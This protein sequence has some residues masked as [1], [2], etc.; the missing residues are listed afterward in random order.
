MESNVLK[1]EFHPVAELFPL[2]QGDEFHELAQDIKVNG[3][4]EPIWLHPDGRVL[5]GRN[6]YNACKEV[7]VEP[8]YRTWDGQG[9]LVKFVVSLNLHRRHL[10]S[11][12]RAMVAL[13]AEEELGKEAKE[14]QGQ[15][16]DLRP[17]NI[18]EQ[19]PE[20]EPGEREAR[21]QAADLLGTNPHYV[22]DAKKLTAY[23]PDLAE[24]VKSG[25]MSIPKAKKT[26]EGERASA[27][28][29]LDHKISPVAQQPPPH[30]SHNSGDNEWYT[31][32]EYIG[33]A[34][35]VLGE[36]D[37]DPASSLEANKVVGAA[38]FYT[39]EDNGLTLPWQGRVWMNPPYAAS[40][41]SPFCNKLA[42]SFN[43]GEVTE[44]CVLV[45]NATET[46]WF[47]TLAEV[48]SAICF[49]RGRVRFWHPNKSSAV[50][51]QGQAVIYMGDKVDEFVRAFSSFGMVVS[52]LEPT[53]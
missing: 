5:D 41:I 15:R 27:N 11:S 43:E 34:R 36:F 33:A 21:T 50:P 40:L 48:A 26:I 13:D 7:D 20:S 10:T 42:S 18:P 16:I 44:A 19:I 9:S 37:L 1:R 52:V 2:M 12:Q 53:E 47:H 23:R 38:K 6:R 49:P 17:D 28:R 14:R 32:Q 24:K 29:I 45:N 4:R 30:V 3:L 25:E 35:S 51:L 39:S 8:D 31:P 46:G 22:S